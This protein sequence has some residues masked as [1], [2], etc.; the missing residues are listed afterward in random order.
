M[1]TG[2]QYGPGPGQPDGAAPAGL[3]VPLSYGQEQLWFLDQLSPGET[4]YNIL[5]AWRLHGPLDQ[6]ILSACL[7]LVVARHAALRTVVQVHDGT[8]FQVVTDPAGAGLKVVDLSAQQPPDR[9][10]ALTQALD[11]L[12][13]TP[14]DLSAGPLCRFLLYRLA[15]DEH[16]LCMG[17][18]HLV[19]DGWS[20]AV[21]N[22]EISAAYQ[23]LAV[24]RQPAL[25]PVRA[26]YPDFAREQRERFAGTVLDEELSFWQ[27]RL[28]GL[29]TLELP[30]DRPRPPEGSLQGA[31]VITVLS[32]QARSAATWLAG[33]SGFSLFMVLAA[34]LNVVLNRYSGQDDIGLGVPMLGR[35]A[36]ELED[37]VGL[38]INMTVLRSD[39]SGD[40]SF[41]A[42][43]DRIADGTIELHEHQEVPFNLVVDRIRPPRDPGRNPLFQVAIQL[44]SG[45]TSGDNF[46]LPGISAEYMLLPSVKSR[47]D[48]T[49]NFLD[50]GQDLKVSVEYSADLFARWRIEA[51]IGH[52]E[53]VLTA[54]AANPSAR[55]SRLQLL[56]GAEREA[57]LAAGRGEAVPYSPDP[58]HVIL[59][60]MAAAT[61]D[62]T[63]VVCRDVELSYRE[64]DRRA[65]LL[66]RYLRARGLRAGQVVALVI[67]RD[68]DAYVA[69]AGILK[70][71]GAFAVLDPKLPITRLDF[72]IRDTSAPLVVTRAAL[73]G[74]LPE[75][76]G[77]AA[78]LLD[79]DWPQ[80][81]ATPISEPLAEWTDRDSLAYVLYTSG[82]SGTPKGVMIRHRA[83]AFFAEAYRRS[84]GFGPHDRLL[85]LPSLAFDMSQGEIWTAFSVGATV[86]AVA[87]EE[88]SSPEALAALMREQRVSYAGLPPAMQSVLDPEPYPDLKYIMGGA[89]VLPPELVNKWNL[90]G[91]TYLNLYGPTEAAIA[92]TEYVCEH[93]VWRASPP[94]GRP[95]VNRH[96]YVVDRHGNLVPRGV[97][98]ELLIGGEEGLAVGYLN[99][100]ELTAEKFPADPFA[101]DGRVYR[102]GDLVRWNR[103]L[104]L[105][106]IGRLD[107]QVKLRGLRIELGEIESALAAHPSVA[108]AVVLMRPDRQGEN[109]LIGYVTSSG[110]TSPQPSML[111][112]HLAAQ[113]P[114]YMVPTA[115]VVL[116]EFPLSSGWK[117]D[118]NRLPDPADDDAGA[119]DYV[120]PRD[121]TEEKIAAIFAEVL[122]HAQVGA[123]DGFFALGGNSLQAMRAVSRIN[124]AFGIK[125]SI[126][127]LYGSATL[128]EIGATVAEKIASRPGEEGHA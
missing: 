75:P 32:A 69:L 23:A 24:G 42:L 122:G 9:E 92:C 63:A 113:L 101:A 76:A 95:E 126:R 5:L 121:V 29:P 6:A 46:G 114:E 86:V 41:T 99:Q 102:S 97:P 53:S 27:R 39:L 48:V 54:A 30:T 12:T 67:D 4:T 89:E 116:A 98:G 60:N 93:T 45:A 111:R 103:D 77:W 34:A 19:T 71:G 74:Q 123:M 112:E 35:P 107:L 28:G 37:L 43:L 124:K 64:L 65:G 8:P 66:A 61:P 118:R 52:V 10:R 70:A 11:G 50:N 80:I 17:F 79:T 51:M 44:L 26:D 68:L 16:V 117:I 55:L 36:P 104:Q 49:L 109:R 18:H 33:E 14:Y 56:S 115:W 47:F 85:Q 31:S 38:F 119:A 96:V 106:F 110:E 81:E 15:P 58:L 94:I 87:P 83:V 57:L 20:S 82:S 88:A 2:T 22:A 127:L 84:F 62:A 3:T 90:P 7:D 73:A 40:P 25:A 128:T 78:V 100:P 108:R 72:M 1:T 13:A 21:L 59:A 105:E 120:A 125:I 91:R